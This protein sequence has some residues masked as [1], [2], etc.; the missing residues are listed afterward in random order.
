[1][2]E[3][4]QGTFAV[5][6]DSGGIGEAIRNQLLEAGHHVIGV[7][8]K[9]VSEQRSG[10]QSLVFNA[11]AHPCDLSNFADQLDGLEVGQIANGETS[12]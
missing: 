10:Y 7:S 5:I 11:V 3:T 9:G 4:E 12:L 2:A 1:M 6:G 8:R